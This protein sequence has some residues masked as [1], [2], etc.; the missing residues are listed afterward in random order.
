MIIKILLLTFITFA[1]F[2]LWRR[3][4]ENAISL[5]WLILWMIFWIVAA[6]IVA[7][8]EVTQRL[9]QIVG[10][11]R[12]SDLAIYVALLSAYYILFR[13]M[14]RIEKMERDISKIVEELAIRENQSLR[15]GIQ[16]A[17]EPR[18]KK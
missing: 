10:V 4:Q 2:R 18:I 17:G 13:I 16:F 6:S 14:V 5:R 9:A 11:G 7:L 8:P 1:V 12:G 3:H 15:S